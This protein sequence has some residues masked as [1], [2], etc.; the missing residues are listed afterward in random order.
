MILQIFVIINYVRLIGCVVIL[1]VVDSGS[2]FFVRVRWCLGLVYT[3]K[4]FGNHGFGLGFWDAAGL[5][6][7]KLFIVDG[8][9]SSGVGAFDIVC[10][11]F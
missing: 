9:Y 3:K 2:R 11:Y 5:E 10:F 8:A 1:T 6:V 7:E 4:S